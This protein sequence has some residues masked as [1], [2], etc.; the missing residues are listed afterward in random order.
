MSLQKP[1]EYYSAPE[2]CCQIGCNNYK[3]NILGYDRTNYCSLHDDITIC[4]TANC[5]NHRSY[6]GDMRYS[7]CSTHKCQEKYCNDDSNCNKHQ[8]K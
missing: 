8:N 2:N 5:K 4:S 1:Y 7:Y 6:Y 3:E